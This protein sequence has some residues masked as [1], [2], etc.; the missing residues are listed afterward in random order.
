MSSYGD[1]VGQLM[2]E[3]PGLPY[4]AA[5]KILN[6][7]WAD[8]R[9]ERLWSWQIDTGEVYTADQLLTGAVSLTQF[10]ATIQFDATARA[11]LDP[12]AAVAT[13]P[14]IPRQFRVSMGPIYTLID[15]DTATGIGT[16]DRIYAEAPNATSSFLIYKCYYTPPFADHLRYLTILDPITGNSIKG[17][18]LLGSREEI[19]RRDP[20]RGSQGDPYRIFAYQPDST[21]LTQHEWW[22]QPI[23]SRAYICTCVRRGVDLSAPTDVLPSTLNE[24]L[25]TNKA[26]YYAYRWALS[27]AGTDPALKGINWMN[28]MIDVQKQYRLDLVKAKR[29]DNEILL[30][31]FVNWNADLQNFMGPIDSNWAQ[32]HGVAAY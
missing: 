15:Y 5:Q 11:I 9:D 31:N 16:L 18:Q 20:M 22:P 32:S 8:V 3:V 14:L 12:L 13:P 7:G 23:V 17:K 10:L 21:G 26:L 19:N 4:P 6:K 30:T 27:H 28:L 29:E 24:N 25:V 1:M 2:G